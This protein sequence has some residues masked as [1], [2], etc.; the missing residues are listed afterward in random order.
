MAESAKPV[1][2]GLKMLLSGGNRTGFLDIFPFAKSIEDWRI[3]KVPDVKIA[4]RIFYLWLIVI[5]HT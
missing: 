5:A 3:C 1:E 2:A 4:Y